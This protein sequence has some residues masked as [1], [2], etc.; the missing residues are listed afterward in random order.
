M[1]DPIQRA[2]IEIM[3]EQELLKLAPF[4]MREIWERYMEYFVEKLIDKVEE[5][6]DA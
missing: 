5:V 4:C 1:F 3:F 2:K 6:F